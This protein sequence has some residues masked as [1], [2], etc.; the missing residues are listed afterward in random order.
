MA[1]NLSGARGWVCSPVEN[2]QFSIDFHFKNDNLMKVR[3]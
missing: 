3:E 2:K 1:F